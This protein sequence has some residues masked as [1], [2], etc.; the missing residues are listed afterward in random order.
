MGTTTLLLPR[1]SLRIIANSVVKLA[2]TLADDYICVISSM[3]IGDETPL[4]YSVNK[5]LTKDRLCGQY[6]E[7]EYEKKGKS[8]GRNAD[9]RA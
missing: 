7:Q 5:Q 8:L 3:V 6:K 4:D 1:V 2:D 9:D